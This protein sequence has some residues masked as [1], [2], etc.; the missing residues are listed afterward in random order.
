MMADDGGIG[1]ITKTYNKFTAEMTS[2]VEDCFLTPTGKIKYREVYLWWT[3]PN[4][5]LGGIKPMAMLMHNPDKVLQ[6]IKAARDG[7]IE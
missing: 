2:R 3:T 7:D 5:M 1:E 4:P 6:F